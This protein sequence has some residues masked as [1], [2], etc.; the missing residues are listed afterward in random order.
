MSMRNEKDTLDLIRR[1]SLAPGL[2]GFEQE[3][4]AIIQAEIGHISDSAAVDRIGNAVFTFEPTAE[5]RSVDT[6]PNFGQVPASGQ[7]PTILL[8]AHQDEIGFMVASVLPSGFLRVESLGGWNPVTLPSSPVLVVN[9]R[10]ESIPGIIGHIPPHFLKDRKSDIPQIS[11]LFID[12]GAASDRE[13]AEKFSIFPGDL[14]VP[15]TNYSWNEKSRTLMSKAFDDRIG[16]AAL[17]ELGLRI[18]GKPGRKNRLRLAATVQEEVGTRGAAVLGNYTDADIAL[19]IE[20]APAD[21]IPGGPEI[22]QTRIRGGAHVRIYD[23]TMIA[24]PGLLRLIREK[25]EGGSIPI[26]ETVRRG[27]GTD[28]RVLHLAGNG[29]PSIVTGVPVRYAHSHNCLIHLD[30]FYALVDLL[31]AVCMGAGSETLEKDEQR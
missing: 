12:I 16:I 28:G 14:V 8:A 29:I 20:G 3:I 21:D 9:R 2:P 10:K 30:D 17:I 11:E 26:Q 5:N 13:A 6:A 27:G 24:H 7:V 1:L 23:P 19:I 15:V 18:A 4:T 25:A 31:E 22:P